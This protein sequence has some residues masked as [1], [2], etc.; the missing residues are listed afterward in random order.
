[1]TP[2]FRPSPK[3]SAHH[4][5][6]V[7]GPRLLSEEPRPPLTSE[8]TDRDFFLIFSDFLT[9]VFCLMSLLRREGS[10]HRQAINCVAL[11]PS[12]VHF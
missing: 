9:W 12:A 11:P 3:H 8:H 6:R 2:D 1:M 5:Q 10:S 4:V 7:L